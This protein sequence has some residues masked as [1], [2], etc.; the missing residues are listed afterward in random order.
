[1]E[2]LPFDRGHYLCSPHVY[3]QIEHTGIL[4]PGASGVT[5][6]MPIEAVELMS[7]VARYYIGGND[8]IHRGCISGEHYDYTFDDNPM[9]CVLTI[10]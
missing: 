10:S 5:G 9:L 7:N 1:M 8:S 6:L 2:A 4:S 3:A